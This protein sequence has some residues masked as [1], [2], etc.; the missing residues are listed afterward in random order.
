MR[1]QSRVFAHLAAGSK[2]CFRNHEADAAFRI[3]HAH[4][5]LVFGMIPPSSAPDVASVLEAY[6]QTMRQF[7]EAQE[8]LALRMFSGTTTSPG[9]RS[10][11]KA[12]TAMQRWV[13]RAWD[14]PLPLRASTARWEG[15]W[16]LLHAPGRETAQL[17]AALEVRGAVVM[18]LP[19]GIGRD[20]ATLEAW[21]KHVSK[22][23][24]DIS[25]IIHVAAPGAAITPDLSIWRGAHEQDVKQLFRLLRA[26]ATS[27]AA[28]NGRVIS[29]TGLGG[30][31]GRSPA[32]WTTA[33]TAGGVAG[34]LRTFE[35]EWP[36][37]SARTIDLDTESWEGLPE[38]LAGELVAGDSAREIGYIAAQRQIWDAVVEDPVQSHE[39]SPEA[40]WVVL[41]T[42]GAR[43]ITA[44]V[45]ATAI[46]PGITILLAGRTALPGAES[47]ETRSLPD[48]AALRPVLREHL[49][50][51]GEKATPVLIEKK[52]AAL[53]RDRE[54]QANI[55]RFE[56]AGAKVVY[57]TVDVG[58][59]EAFTAFLKRI[60]TEFGRIDAVIHG[61]GLI[62]DK[63]LVEK[64]DDS[65][66]RVFNTKADSAWVLTAN[67]HFE[68]LKWIALFGSVAGRTGNRG[69]CDYAA[70]N[71]VVNRV[72]WWLRWQHPMLKVRVFNWGPWESG[73]ASEAVQK[74]F[75]S[76]GVI[77]IPPE[78]GFAWFREWML[79]PEG[80]NVETV[81]GIFLPT[82][83][84]PIA[85]ETL[86]FP[87]LQ[88][89]AGEGEPRIFEVELDPVKMP[90]LDDHRLDGVAVLPAAGA[91]ELAAEAAQML[92]PEWV[93][94]GARDLRV[95]AGVKFPG[96]EKQKMILKARRLPD[97][98]N[99]AT[100]TVEV[101]LYTGASGVRAHYKV[102]IEMAT[103]GAAPLPAP[104]AARGDTGGLKMREGYA[105]YCFHGPALQ[106]LHRLDL[107]D[108]SK[109]VCQGR[110]CTPGEMVGPG[111][112]D[113]VWLIDPGVVDAALQANLI[114][115]MHRVG[116]YALPTHFERIRC[117][118]G[119]LTFDANLTF[120]IDM[121]L[122]PPVGIVSNIRIA[123]QR[124]LLRME[125]TGIRS[126][127]SAAL[128]RVAPSV[129]L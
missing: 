55:A 31:F 81:D 26:T 10:S 30:A 89:S 91:L 109:I 118:G 48:A 97:D 112:A 126:A 19:E 120:D 1:N 60:Y 25:G 17:K 8:K 124:G 117:W 29:V 32:A 45:V 50:A 46:V 72:G 73:M 96:D 66:D 76:R 119:P 51:A 59:P 57:C 15:G 127:R 47:A 40:A 67:L 43:G 121:I 116:E 83:A 105:R 14:R 6:Q 24:G 122:E 77:P 5:L 18:V 115:V 65:F 79:S 74:Q 61:A 107:L 69:Q 95:M 101:L 56:A 4:C 64:Q 12:T 100:S 63:L 82:G 34:L 3:A 90:L 80:N 21:L 94:V 113:R 71:E 93:V 20:A 13:P 129:S 53:L 99:L 102:F 54:I 108:T 110:P 98:G 88:G 68:Q 62:E 16:I 87:W 7:L 75:R 2:R 36:Q 44:G 104:V 27:L 35:I 11:T 41:A 58:D 128:A 49:L 52:V 37:V 22:E 70:T 85:K 123:D 114:W 86:G 39:A 103:E 33:A 84:H 23:S 78:T 28:A 125:L 92:L 9:A 42:G 38:I 111:R 106:L